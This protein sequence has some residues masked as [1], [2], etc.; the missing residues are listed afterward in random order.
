[1]FKPET[2]VI[3][4]RRQGTSPAHRSDSRVSTTPSSEN[5]KTRIP[6]RS[7]DAK[8]PITKLPVRSPYIYENDTQIEQ[9]TPIDPDKVYSD[10][11]TS[12]E[13]QKRIDEL[14]SENVQLHDQ[15]RELRSVNIELLRSCQSL[16]L[17]QLSN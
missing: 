7:L 13:L 12:A 10:N 16:R 8:I 11:H 6:V 5:K 15:I 3:H 17:H 2:Q 4:L 1:M 14:E 9:T